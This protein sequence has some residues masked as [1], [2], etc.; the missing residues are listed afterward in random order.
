VLAVILEKP[1]TI[2]PVRLVPEYQADGELLKVYPELKKDLGVPWVGVITQALAYYRPFF[3]EAWKQL[4]PSVQTHFFEKRCE[5]IRLQ[6][7]DGVVSQLKVE[8]Q[9]PI[10]QELGYKEREIKKIQ[11]TI[12]VLDYGNPKYL[13]FATVVKYG[14]LEGKMGGQNPDD[15]YDLYPR[16]PVQAGDK[17][18]LMVEEHHAAGELKEI[19]DDIK[20]TLQLPF[21]NSDYKAQGRWPS[22]LRVAWSHLK[23][24]VDN[25]EYV[26]IRKNIHDMAVDT[27]RNLPYSYLLDRKGACSV[28]MQESEIDELIEVISLFQYLLSGLIVN[29]TH[30]KASLIEG[31]SIY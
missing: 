22:Y 28:G 18:L 31:K 29:V 7:W 1:R 16:S 17:P 8:N 30:F 21:V 13:V 2:P 26:A 5:Q 3:I 24:M 6:S 23:P 12:D 15:P 27:A 19:Y 11:D 9:I 20:A 4:Q 25:P 14:L 10:L